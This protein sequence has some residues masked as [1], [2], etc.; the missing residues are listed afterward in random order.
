MNPSSDPQRIAGA[1]RFLAELEALT[2]A[3]AS[4][5]PADELALRRRR[6]E[7]VRRPTGNHEERHVKAL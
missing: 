3:V 5:P 4:R 7:R 2:G 6:L 1:L